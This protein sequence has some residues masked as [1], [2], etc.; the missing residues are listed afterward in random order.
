L[1]LAERQERCRPEW[2]LASWGS[3]VG[4]FFVEKSVFRK[5][6]ARLNLGARH[7][8]REVIFQLHAVLSTVACSR[9]V[10]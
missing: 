3:L 1:P 8:V 2:D 10:V 6:A 5:I 9:A 4:W 7:R